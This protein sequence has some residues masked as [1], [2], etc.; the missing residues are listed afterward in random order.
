VSANGAKMSVK[1]WTTY[2]K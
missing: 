1:G 2:Y